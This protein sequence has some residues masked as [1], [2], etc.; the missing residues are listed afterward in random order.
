[1]RLPQS[2][3]SPIVWFLLFCLLSVFIIPV[4]HAQ[5]RDNA[6]ANKAGVLNVNPSTLDF[7]SVQVGH[8]MTLVTTLT[9]VGRADLMFYY[10][11]TR[12]QEFA[13]GDVGLPLTLGPGQ[14]Y[15]VSITFTPQSSHSSSGDF[16]L[17]SKLHHTAK[18][19][20]LTGTGMAAGQ[21][22]V[23]PSALDFGN[24]TVGQ[25]KT[26]PGTLTAAGASVVIS[27]AT[28]S[29][30]EFVLSGVSFPVTLAAGQSAG[31]TMKFA[32]QAKGGAS[33]TVNFDSD[34]ANS[35]TQESALGNGINPPQP[36]VVDLQWDPGAS[37]VVGYDVYRSSN[38]GGPY[39]RINST[40]D[41]G[42]S[43]VDRTVENGKTYFYVT[44]AV[45]SSGSESDYSNEA[46]AVIP[47]Q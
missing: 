40:L 16:W 33:A 25:S 11:G 37:A 29:S 18:V 12:G 3:F 36:H 14:S 28:S 31:F 39:A 32:P 22:S 26:M 4:A 43:Y 34:A 45:D 13:V 5:G 23:S 46:Q 9:N 7:G 47:S 27:S 30:P 20:T 42:T 24:V 10:I 6:G 15:T 35:P 1:M 38:P 41:P 17:G 44:T 19:A 2:G 21:L 8:S